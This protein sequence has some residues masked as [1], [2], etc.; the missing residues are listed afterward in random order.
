MIIV[1]NTD[2]TRDTYRP[3]NM[4]KKERRKEIRFHNYPSFPIEYN[5]AEW[6]QL[7]PLELQDCVRAD[8]ISVNL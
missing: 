5:N 8:A 3:A 7:L 4:S 6:K 2:F 1:E